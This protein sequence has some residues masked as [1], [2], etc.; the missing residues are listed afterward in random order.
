MSTSSQFEQSLVLQRLCSE[1]ALSPG[2][3][4]ISVLHIGLNMV[5]K[6]WYVI[7]SME[8]S[9]N[10][11]YVINVCFTYNTY[12]LMT[13]WVQLH[14]KNNIAA[15][16][17]TW[18]II[19]SGQI[20]ASLLSLCMTKWPFKWRR[21]WRYVHSNAKKC[22]VSN[23]SV[24][25]NRTV[26]QPIYKYDMM[27]VWVPLVVNMMGV[28]IYS[29]YTKGL[30]LKNAQHHVLTTKITSQEPNTHVLGNLICRVFNMW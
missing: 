18:R 20:V 27:C 30:T 24:G 11:N 29:Q 1:A 6:W 7:L 19:V 15:H 22:K 2:T 21:G 16:W 17:W 12:L 23:N 5:F 4:C 3:W 25:P 14:R 9:R 8:Q 10:N 13:F 28:L 26:C